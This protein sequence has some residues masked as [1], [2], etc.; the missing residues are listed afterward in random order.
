MLSSPEGPIA[1]SLGGS[2]G[3]PGGGRRSSCR[4]RRR[5]AVL[6]RGHARVGEA[7]ENPWSGSRRAPL[8]LATENDPAEKTGRRRRR[9]PRSATP[10]SAEGRA[11]HR[12]FR[13]VGPRAGGAP[14]SRQARSP[15]RARASRRPR[16][17]GQHRPGAVPSSG[18]A[19]ASASA[20]RARERG[21]ERSRQ[22]GLP[23][24]S[25][26]S[27]RVF[28]S[29]A[30]FSGGSPGCCVPR[31]PKRLSELANAGRHEGVA[32]RGEEHGRHAG[33]VHRSP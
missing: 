26:A 6:T 10:A 11:K 28:T 1:T 21:Q 17:D 16:V 13:A 23:S 4:L 29:P 27:S 5:S 12:L 7:P 20:P 22:G 18:P 8:T 32:D 30:A 24:T 9:R 19:S 33:D 25:A 14:R 15:A 2:R 31:G 3:G